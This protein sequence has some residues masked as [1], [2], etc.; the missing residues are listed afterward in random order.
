M[1]LATCGLTHRT[2]P[3][4]SSFAQVAHTQR[5]SGAADN[6][7]KAAGEDSDRRRHRSRQREAGG[8]GSRARSLPLL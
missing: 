2:M 8:M 1:L 4:H 3:S 7:S 5:T 6:P